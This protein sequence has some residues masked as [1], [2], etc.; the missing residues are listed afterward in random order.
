[1]LALDPKQV[2]DGGVGLGNGGSSHS[3][4]ALT[5]FRLRVATGKNIRRKLSWGLPI[6]RHPREVD[7]HVCGF[8]LRH[9]LRDVFERGSTEIAK[10]I[11]EL[12]H[13][14]G[15]EGVGIGKICPVS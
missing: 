7:S 5:P 10:P 12:V 15:A 11:L 6:C 8:P 9:A 1:M 2:V 4:S 14:V 13:K 3:G